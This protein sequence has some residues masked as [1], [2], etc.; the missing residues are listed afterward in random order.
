MALISPQVSARTP[1]NPAQLD[2]AGEA[3]MSRLSNEAAS[4]PHDNQKTQ[5]IDNHAISTTIYER[6]D[7]WRNISITSIGVT[8]RRVVRA[9]NS[10]SAAKWLYVETGTNE[11]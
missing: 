1:E 6:K 11:T 2:S 7:P 8:V 5:R 9:V 10:A 3:L 4:D